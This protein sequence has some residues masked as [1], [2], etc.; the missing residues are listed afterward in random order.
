MKNS[1]GAVPMDL[2]KSGGMP[3]PTEIFASCSEIVKN[4]L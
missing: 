1:K 3:P 2:E 4:I